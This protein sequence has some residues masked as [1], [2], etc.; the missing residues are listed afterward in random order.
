VNVFV[1]VAPAS[2]VTV[3]VKTVAAS[4]V[5]GVPLTAPV[6]VLKLIPVGSVPPLS[7]NVYGTV[8]PAAVTGVN[9]GIEVLTVP[10]VLGTA[11]VVVSATFT[12]SVN[13]L[14]EVAPA[15]SVAVAVKAIA[16]SVVV[17]VPLTALVL[18]LKL[19]PVGSVPP[20]IANVYGSVPPLAVTAM[21]VGIRVFTVP[22]GCGTW[23]R[24]VVS[25]RFT[26]SV[27]V[28]DEVAP[29]ASVAVTVKAVVVSLVVGV[30]LTAPV[31]VL[32]LIPVG[33]V[34]PLSANVYGTVPPAAVTGVNVGIEVLNVPAVLGTAWVVVTAPFTVSVNVWDELAPTL[35]VAV[36]V[37]TVATSVVV[38]VP[39]TA[40][41]LV[42]KLI[43]VGSA[44]ALSANVY[45]C[46]PPAAVTGVNV[47]ITVFTVPVVLGT[48]WVI[49]SAPFTV[50]VNV[51]DDVAPTL[52]VAVTVKSVA[53][54]VVVGVP[55]TAPVLVLTLIPVGSVPPL[56]ANVYGSVPPAAVTGVNVG[57]TV[58]TVP[59]VLGTAWVVV[60][61]SFT[62]SV[63]VWDEVAPTL[64][65]AV[66]VNV[67]SASGPVGVPL[68]APVV[69]LNAKPMSVSGAS[70]LTANE[71]GAVPPLAVTGV[72]VGIR[73]FTV[74]VVLG[75]ACV[76]V[77][78]S[79]TVS[80]NVW[81][82]FAAAASVTVTVKTVAASVV[83]GVPL[84]SPV[85]VLKLIPVGSAAPLSANV[86]GSVPPAA[87]TGVNVGIRV[88][89]VPVVLGTAW[90]V[91]SAS[92]TVSVN[93]WDEV[94][95][96]LSVAVTVKTFVASVVVGVP[97]T[98]P[99]LVLTLIP[100]GSAPPLSANV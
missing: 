15:A 18:V 92:F 14:D 24:I 39:L 16:A 67:V 47:G 32:K 17:G 53:T 11:C 29:A 34:P 72:N 41:V 66:T 2:S 91:V 57:I 3:T 38:G 62:M 85:L 4:V 94:A 48:A 89:T 79:F 20:L 13:V 40:P 43:P 99:V 19:I 65:V 78:A 61:A 21:N 95:P 77:S 96:T 68:T 90:V 70:G 31:L 49:V 10:V 42:L 9:V 5:V 88:F 46:V 22:V 80:V 63:N 74:P 1:E 97:L 51:W 64:S 27:N 86:Y 71:T 25:A 44:A 8:P 59:V 83:V 81:D 69:V 45:G 60:S 12:L 30:P 100:V 55:L 87:A 54:S 98:S 93:V 36:T 37:K 75:T 56:S 82:E 7:A 6:L 28:W 33:S 26:V 35:S 73:V 76:V 52:S 84:T 50:R 23:S 58:F